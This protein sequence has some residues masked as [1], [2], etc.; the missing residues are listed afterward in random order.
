[1][2]DNGNYIPCYP[3][4]CSFATTD[5]HDN[6]SFLYRI[7]NFQLP[8]ILETENMLND[9]MKA[10]IERYNLV[11][12]LIP[13][14]RQFS[15]IKDIK[16]DWDSVSIS[17]HKA[18]NGKAALIENIEFQ[19]FVNN[20]WV[21]WEE[22]SNGTKRLFYIIGNVT[23]ATADEIILIEHPE[24]VIH[25]YQL[26]LLMNFLKSHR[27]DKQIIMST[28][29]PQILNCLGEDELD[30]IIVTRHEGK[31]GTKL[32]HLSEEEK[33]YASEYMKNEAFLSDY[34]LLSG[35]VDEENDENF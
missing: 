16:I 30:R 8:H 7:F 21:K 4:S 17:L 15:P 14:L 34:W 28:H 33:G 10:I 35:F 12:D 29:S 31:A 22:L 13:N 20:E 9:I 32:Y 23:Y 3:T 2:I 11:D 27:S 18:P 6:Y 5:S 24:L 25:P 19:F 1:M 26:S